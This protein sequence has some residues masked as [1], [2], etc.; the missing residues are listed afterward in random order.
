LVRWGSVRVRLPTVVVA[1]DNARVNPGINQQRE[2]M[3]GI[4]TAGLSDLPIGSDR[5]KAWKAREQG[6]ERNFCL[7]K[8]SRRAHFVTLWTDP[9]TF[10]RKPRKP[11][12][13]LAA[14]AR[15]DG[16]SFPPRGRAFSPFSGAAPAFGERKFNGT[17]SR[18]FYS[19]AQ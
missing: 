11:R 7:L 18:R 1:R 4:R 17:I 3:A 13:L 5:R 10:L 9:R 15:A 6:R 8:R 19:R 2:L 14:F 12:K 16:N